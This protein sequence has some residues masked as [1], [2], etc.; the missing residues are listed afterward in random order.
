MLNQPILASSQLPILGI[1][2]NKVCTDCNLYPVA[3]PPPPTPFRP[4]AVEARQ[5]TET[6]EPSE[7]GVHDGQEEDQSLYLVD[8]T[9]DYTNDNDTTSGETSDAEDDALELVDECVAGPSDVAA[10]T[11]PPLDGFSFADVVDTVMCIVNEVC[12]EEEL[13]E[14]DVWVSQENYHKLI[15]NGLLTTFEI[16][17]FRT[18][19]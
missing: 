10:S 16:E 3:P 7:V 18:L 13:L 19:T 12:A 9:Y 1:K 14:E 2:H 15:P 4:A 5:D 11:V 17:N 8:A 6:P